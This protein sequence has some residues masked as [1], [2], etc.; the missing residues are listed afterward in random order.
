MLLCS[1][2]YWNVIS[3]HYS[4]GDPSP[5]TA[6]QSLLRLKLFWSG[7]NPDRNNN[8]HP[9]RSHQKYQKKISIN[10]SVISEI[11][12][13]PPKKIQDLFLFSVL[14]ATWHI[15][16]VQRIPWTAMSMTRGAQG[17]Q[18]PLSDL[19]GGQPGRLI[20]VKPGEMLSGASS[21]HRM[22]SSGDWNLVIEIWSIL[23]SN[24]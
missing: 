24:G 7:K 9:A 12:W 4:N 5:P 17:Q 13:P 20:D 14:A 18:F 6:N 10:Q 1:P 16:G 23:V 21:E 8:S 11:P 3:S 15:F 2:I 19:L 22:E